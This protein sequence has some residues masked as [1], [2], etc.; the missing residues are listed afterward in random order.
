[1]LTYGAGVL[2][3]VI[4]SLPVELHIPGYSF[5]GPGTRLAERLAA[6]DRGINQLDAAC[7]EHDISYSKHKDL[8][9]RH[10]ADKILEERAWTRVKSK[11]GK[12][13]ERTA[14][15][16]VTNAMKLKR[17]LG[18]GIKKKK[19]K[20]NFRQN[21]I[22][23]VKKVLKSKKLRSKNFLN[24]GIK[25]AL[26]ASKTAVKNAGGKNS[27]NVPR[28]LPIPK[29][30]GV[31]PLIP[32][33]AGLSALGSL[34]GGAAAISKTIQTTNIA[35]K[36]LEEARRHN[37]ALESIKTGNGLYLKAKK[38]GFGLYLKKAKN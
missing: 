17:K 22:A 3:K 1:M 21:V 33:F 20:H 13:G 34:A 31:L 14:A 23:P 27:I 9:D 8:T 5:C 11:D 7:R 38:N 24:E 15:W 29:R 35:R 10:K 12:F 19:K 2:N 30:G 36:N 32:I 4:D 16:A 6:G 18:M 28:V 37:K 26:A 25:L